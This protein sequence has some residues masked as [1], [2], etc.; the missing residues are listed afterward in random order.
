MKLGISRRITITNASKPPEGHEVRCR[1]STAGLLILT[2]TVQTDQEFML[3]WSIKSIWLWLMFDSF[4]LSSKYNR[5]SGLSGPAKLLQPRL[6]AWRWVLPVFWGGVPS[7]TN[8]PT[9]VTKT[10][11]RP[12][13]CAV[14]H[15]V[16]RWTGLLVVSMMIY[17]R[18]KLLAR[19]A[20]TNTM[21][22][23]QI[24]C[25]KHHHARVN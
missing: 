6:S 1:Y 14:T 11:I 10:A 8:Q 13:L 2:V 7:Q 20:W 15:N 4:L 23:R 25:G 19:F 24:I 18:Q 3:E 22:R 21:L 12:K 16:I 17:Q 9:N 5:L